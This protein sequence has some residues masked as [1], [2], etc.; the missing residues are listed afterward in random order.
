MSI[1]K[2]INEMKRTAL[3]FGV[4]DDIRQAVQQGIDKLTDL[5]AEV[6]RLRKKYPSE[7][8][9]WTEPGTVVMFRDD[10]YEVEFP[11]IS[12]GLT[13][14]APERKPFAID[15]EGVTFLY[16]IHPIDAEGDR[17]DDLNWDDLKSQPGRQAIDSEGDVWRYNA[18]TAQFE[19]HYGDEEW[20]MEA[21]SDDYPPLEWAEHADL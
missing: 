13:W 5:D 8:P 7:N 14:V 12:D 10:E 21:L 2:L 19:V 4:P 17:R 1:E 9:L 15:A 16:R 6:A 11:A 18:M 3:R 20:H